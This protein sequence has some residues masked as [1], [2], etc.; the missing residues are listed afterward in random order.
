MDTVFSFTL[1][2]EMTLAISLLAPPAFKFLHGKAKNTLSKL[3]HLA[4]FRGVRLW[5]RERKYKYLTE[6]R[7]TRAIKA[8]VY[9]QISQ[10]NTYLIVFLIMCLFYFYLLTHSPLK[11]LFNIEEWVSVLL[12]SPLYY[13]ELKWLQ[14]SGQKKALL[15][16]MRRKRT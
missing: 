1:S 8:H 16:I 11:G 7:R 15:R 3:N 14:A 12:A 6:L 5:R 10:A 4:L 2:N 13:F 9:E